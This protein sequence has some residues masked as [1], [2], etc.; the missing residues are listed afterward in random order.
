MSVAIVL[1]CDYSNLSTHFS[2]SIA[3]GGSVVHM[4]LWS[5]IWLSLHIVTCTLWDW[6]V[7]KRIKRYLVTAGHTTMS[8]Q[9]FLWGLF[10]DTQQWKCFL[11]GRIP[12]LVR[13]L[14]S[15]CQRVNR[16]TRLRQQSYRE[17]VMASDAMSE[18]S[19][20]RVELWVGWV[21]ESRG[22]SVVVVTQLWKSVVGSP[23]RL[24]CNWL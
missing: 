1:T 21:R 2:F 9:C 3:R 17:S 12:G 10:R 16:R 4:Y 14:V 8:R 20:C 22:D 24:G 7:N 13:R 6:W 11:W 23:G 18:V 19:G 5:S 15:T